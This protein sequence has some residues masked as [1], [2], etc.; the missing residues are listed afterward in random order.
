MPVMVSFT[1][2][3]NWPWP[4]S[5]PLAMA[6]A[7]PEPDINV[8][9]ATT[10]P[11]TTAAARPTIDTLCTMYRL[12]DSYGLVRRPTIPKRKTRATRPSSVAPLRYFSPSAGAVVLFRN[13]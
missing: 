13:G 8:E 3:G 10:T 1:E 7:E 5:A 4:A 9:A 6:P 12:L 11:V 2:E